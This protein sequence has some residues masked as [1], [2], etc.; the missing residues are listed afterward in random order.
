VEK[1]VLTGNQQKAPEV[2]HR[3]LLQEAFHTGA[4]LA[5]GD[6]SKITDAL[7]TYA[8]EALYTGTLFF[9]GGKAVVAAAAIGALNEVRTDESLKDGAVDAVLGSVKGAGTKLVF[10][11]IGGFEF[12]KTL[13]N[14]PIK[15]VVMGSAATAI[16]SAL[17]R[18][19]YDQNGKFDLRTGLERTAQSVLSPKALAIDAATF[20]LASSA[21][22]GINRL[23]GGLL[24]RSPGLNVML[25][26]GTFGIASGGINEL[27]KQSESGNGFDIGKIASQAAIHGA[28][29]GLAAGPAAFKVGFAPR[30]IPDVA[31][32]SPN[33]TR[34]S[35]DSTRTSQNAT[36]TDVLGLTLRS[37]TNE[38]VSSPMS[39]RELKDL[40]GSA[41]L[42]AKEFGNSGSAL[43]T[44][45]NTPTRFVTAMS[46][47]GSVQ[48]DLPRGH[49]T[50]QELAPSRLIA[51]DSD[52][53]RIS[54]TK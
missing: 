53:K 38:T 28:I 42:G 40:G 5:F 26:G 37:P 27:A 46:D 49:E 29:D 32:I 43:E 19:T 2:E 9:P 8:P 15:G 36:S 10:D 51:R 34:T 6:K 7:T 21:S 13:L 33:A 17:T 24:A 52:G 41:N 11:K 23:T 35:P 47:H 4:S 1:L 22:F 3:S 14:A 50:A 48:I 16:N 25:T 12:S 45:A 20:G 18:S 54:I 39:V 30:P 31:R 44:S